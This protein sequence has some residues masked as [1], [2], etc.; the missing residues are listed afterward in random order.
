M[1]VWQ[2]IVEYWELLLSAVTLIVSVIVLI[3][4]KRP[5]TE[6]TTAIYQ[7]CVLAIGEAEKTD[8]KG[9]RKLQFAVDLVSTL[10]KAR[11]PDID[12]N[13]YVNLIVN[14][15]ESIL[16]TPQKKGENDGKKNS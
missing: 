15:I 3:V 9:D 2:F 10:L 6:L 16:S 11:W 7:C 13:K 14:T 1:N 4:K 8:Y 5:V 12:V